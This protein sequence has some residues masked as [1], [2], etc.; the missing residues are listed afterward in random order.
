M[1]ELWKEIPRYPFCEASDD[2]RIRYKNGHY[3]HGL[4]LQMRPLKQGT[5]DDHVIG[6]SAYLT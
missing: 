1:E 2:G 4:A 6:N 5:K 3:V